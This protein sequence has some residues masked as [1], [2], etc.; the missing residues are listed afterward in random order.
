MFLRRARERALFFCDKSLVK[1][2]YD[3]RATEKAAVSLNRTHSL[4]V[5]TKMQSTPMSTYLT[6][7]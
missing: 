7:G 3:H 2:V 1:T 4:L 6:Y 5:S